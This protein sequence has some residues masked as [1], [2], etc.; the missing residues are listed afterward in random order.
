MNIQLLS[1][2]H[3]EFHADNGRAFAES[4]EPAAEVLVLAG[5]MLVL[6][7][8]Q[9]YVDAL[10]ALARKYTHVL[11][12]IGNHE[13]YLASV[14]KALP[15]LDRLAARIPNLTVLKAG[16][17][18]VIDGVRFLGDA[19]W[20][21]D[22]LGNE[23]FARYMTDFRVIR[24]LVPWVYA[25][26]RRFLAWLD[27]ELREG[28]VV[29]THH[30]P[31]AQSIAPEHFGSQLNR[32]FLCDVEPLIHARRPQLWMHGHTH[33]SADYAVGVTRVVCNPYGYAPNDLNPRWRGDLAVPATA[34]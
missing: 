20:F 7:D 21:P 6:R 4:I 11:E 19:M 23:A 10:S 5:D 17:V 3:F 18:K 28:D 2:C 34:P 24:D 31:T 27:R 12:I 32:F 1:D 15:L 13:L 9:L 25:E 29:V 33:S 22:A 14:A 26:N 16:E 30:L 8:W